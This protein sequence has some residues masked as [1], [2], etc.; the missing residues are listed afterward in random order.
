PT[1]ATAAGFHQYDAQLED[2]SKVAIQQQVPVLKS[3]K[4]QFERV[5]AAR[6]SPE[7]AVDRELVLGDIN[8]RLLEIEN[9]R[10]WETNP[11]HYSSGI[12]NSI[13][14]VMAR[15]FAPPEQRLKSVIAREMQIPK[16][17]DEARKNLKNPPLLYVNV[18]L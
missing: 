15:S 5:D 17:F 14:L 6:L 7:V 13:F 8:S 16:V 1:S 4:Q 2:Y 3:F 11:D 10:Q 9:I 12:T 18:A